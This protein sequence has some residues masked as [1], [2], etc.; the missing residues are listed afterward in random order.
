MYVGYPTDLGGIIHLL[1]LFM[2]S[3]SSAALLS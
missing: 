1:N 2:Y 3:E